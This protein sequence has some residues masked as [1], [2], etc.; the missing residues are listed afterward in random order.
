MFRL[1]CSKVCTQTL[2]ADVSTR[3]SNPTFGLVRRLSQREQIISSNICGVKTQDHQSCKNSSQ[4]YYQQYQTSP[5]R[6]INI[7][8]KSKYSEFLWTPATLPTHSQ[9]Q[10]RKYSGQSNNPD[11]SSKTSQPEN[12]A[13]E[14][15]ENIY[16]I[17]NLLTVGRFIVAPYL[18]YMVLQENFHTG[19][20]L[21][22]IAALTDIADGYIARNWKG[23]IIM[24]RCRQWYT[25]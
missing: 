12:S 21:L 10:T 3:L 24:R 16:T 4:S 6:L 18:G 1:S 14:P 20:V 13:S 9:G 11:D 23:M 25:R 5:K 15:K 2:S 17:P 8:S 19:C 7:W 22:G